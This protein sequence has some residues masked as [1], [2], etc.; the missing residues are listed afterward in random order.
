[1]VY[2]YEEKQKT[3][4]RGTACMFIVE[5]CVKVHNCLFLVNN[6]FLHDE[7]HDDLVMSNVYQLLCMHTV[8]TSVYIVNHFVRRCYGK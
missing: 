7:S 1:M 3:K 6:I 8:V 2:N 4:R 5:V